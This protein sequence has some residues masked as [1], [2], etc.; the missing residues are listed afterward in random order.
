MNNYD[1][2]PPPPTDPVWWAIASMLFLAAI[3]VA[4]I[5][6]RFKS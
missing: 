1:M 4:I 3:F 2:E 5:L 6:C